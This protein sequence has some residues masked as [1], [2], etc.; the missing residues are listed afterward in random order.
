M[1]HT[2]THT[3][4][5]DT[6][7]AIATRLKWDL[8]AVTAADFIEELSG[9]IAP[10]LDP[11]DVNKLVDHSHTIANVCLLCKSHNTSIISKSG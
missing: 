8:N 7:K 3:N 10:I 1:H 5:Q 4:T 9:R 2:H 11:C 6:E